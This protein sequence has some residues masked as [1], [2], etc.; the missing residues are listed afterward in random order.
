MK[1]IYRLI[2]VLAMGLALAGVFLP[3]LPTTPFV[4]VAAWAFTRGS[5]ALAARLEAHRRLGPLLRNWRERRAV[6][7]HA[8]ILAVVSMTISFVVLLGTLQSPILLAAI[9]VT[10]VA[11][12]SYLLTRPTA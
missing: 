9:A 6:P 4:L 12:A 10:L 8:K 1:A 11:V 3:G 5:P 2:G 7:R